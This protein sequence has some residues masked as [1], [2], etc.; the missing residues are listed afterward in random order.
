ME[1][2][3]K[4]EAVGGSVHGGSTTPVHRKSKKK[5][6][7]PVSFF[8]NSPFL[9][10]I[11]Y[12]N[13]I[14]FILLNILNPSLSTDF[15]VSGINAVSKPW[16]LFTSGF[17]HANLIHLGMNM[18]SLVFIVRSMI[19]VDLSRSAL[20]TYLAA[21]PISGGLA[22][23]FYK[24]E[25]FLV[26]ASGAVFALFGYAFFYRGNKLSRSTMCIDLLISAAIPFFVQFISWQAHL[27]GFIFGAIV[28]YAL[29]LRNY[30][31]K[32]GTRDVLRS[33]ENA[34]VKNVSGKSDEAF[35][36]ERDLSA[37][38]L[39]LDYSLAK[40]DLF[41][42]RGSLMDKR[43]MLIDK[44]NAYVKEPSDLAFLNAVMYVNSFSSDRFKSYF[45]KLCVDNNVSTEGL[46]VTR[47]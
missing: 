17:V 20:V 1:I 39:F 40:F 21:I 42:F 2:K 24:P 46:F 31:R 14:V 11:V 23:L 43:K 44:L 7:S 34:F 8:R 45:R 16:T 26:G 38:H 3:M 37:M 19:G 27:F 12:L 47:I 22:I 4:P 15:A 36:M 5:I 33:T 10:S 32:G 6:G 28:S 35:F 41:P 30:F 18:L 25:M 9:A 29:S 13:V